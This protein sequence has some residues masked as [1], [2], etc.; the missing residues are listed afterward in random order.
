M[1][2]VKAYAKVNLTL[3]VIGKRDDGYHN[4]RSVMQTVD[5]YDELHV[6]KSKTLSLNCN[7]KSIENQDNLVLI[8]AKLLRAESNQDLGAEIILKKGIPL[9]SGLGGGSSDAA[10]ALKALNQLWQLG[11]DN[12]RLTTISASVGSD[13]PFFLNGGLAIVGGRGEHVEHIETLVNGHFVFLIPELDITNKTAWIYSHITPNLF[14]NG[15]RSKNLFSSVSFDSNVDTSLLG[16]V[17]QSITPN[18]IPTIR[19]YQKDILAVG[20]PNALLSGTGP[21]VYSFIQE[22]EVA[23]NVKTKLEELGHSPILAHAIK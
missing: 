14:T 19:E 22:H 1:L 2:K 15:N 10:A 4:I 9:A 8:A 23:L 18:L 16:N 3:E 17:F 13:V 5:I 12:E 7:V 21:S 6:S 11:L 20:G